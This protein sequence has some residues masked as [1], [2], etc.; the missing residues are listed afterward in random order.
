MQFEEYALKSKHVLLR[1][2][3]KLKQIH[4]DVSAS[5][6]TKTIFFGERT[7]T[8]IEPEDYSPIAYPSVKTTEYSSSSW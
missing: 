5:S 6:F 4:K 7:C 8:D 2:D 3:Q 1:A